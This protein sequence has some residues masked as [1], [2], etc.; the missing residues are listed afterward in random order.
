MQGWSRRAQ[1]CVWQWLSL[2]LEK[3]KETTTDASAQCEVLARPHL[4]RFQEAS[5]KRWHPQAPQQLLALAQRVRADLVCRAKTQTS[6]PP[7][8]LPSQKAPLL[9]RY[10]K[11]VRFSK[12]RLCFE[13]QDPLQMTT[14][15]DVVEY[16]C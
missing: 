12:S 5:A 13:D 10:H 7:P 1:A 15:L 8:E 16:V 14:A 4:Q 3:R 2:S 6:P 11:E 9:S